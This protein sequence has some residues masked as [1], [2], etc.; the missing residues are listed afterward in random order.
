M[1]AAGLLESGVPRI[2]ERAAVEGQPTRIVII[3]YIP[4]VGARVELLD[5][6]LLA[7]EETAFPVEELV[8]KRLI[9]LGESSSG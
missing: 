3:K 7:I 1:N 8:G 9:G 4:L 5:R 2:G 6:K